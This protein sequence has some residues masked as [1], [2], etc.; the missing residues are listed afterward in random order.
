MHTTVLANDV[1]RLSSSAVV[2]AGLLIRDQKWGQSTRTAMATRG[3]TTNA[4]PSAAD[5]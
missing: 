3:S 4:A 2:D 1:R 5:R